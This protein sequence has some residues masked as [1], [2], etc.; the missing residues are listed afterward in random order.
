MPTKTRSTIYIYFFPRKSFT[1][2]KLREYVRFLVWVCCDWE[3]T[4]PKQIDV[5]LINQPFSHYTLMLSGNA[6][7]ILKPLKCIFSYILDVFCIIFSL[8]IVD[9]H[10]VQSICWSWDFVEKDS[11]YNGIIKGLSSSILS[12]LSI[13]QGWIFQLYRSLVAI[14]FYFAAVVLLKNYFNQPLRC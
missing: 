10:Q 5:E 1:L 6:W 9:V 8:L 2:G 7:L 4:Q 12:L 11:S 3:T 14:W 13:L